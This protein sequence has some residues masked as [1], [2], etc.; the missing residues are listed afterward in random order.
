VPLRE[1]EQLL[2]AIRLVSYDSI[3]VSSVD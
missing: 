1:D 2:A 3:T